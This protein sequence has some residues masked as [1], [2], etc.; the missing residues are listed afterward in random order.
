VEIDLDLALEGLKEL[1]HGQ[2]LEVNFDGPNGP[3]RELRKR[4][5]LPTNTT[6]YFGFKLNVSLSTGASKLS[7]FGKVPDW[8]KSSVSSSAELLNRFG[9]G[10]GENRSLK[11]TLAVDKP[12]SYGLYLKV[13]E[14]ARVL[15]SRWSG[16]PDEEL[17]HWD[18]NNLYAAFQHK[19][20]NLLEV[21]VSIRNSESRRFMI[22]QE[23][24]VLQNPAE[25]DFAKALRVGYLT[26]DNLIGMKE[27]HTHEHGP[28]FRIEK[29]RFHNLFPGHKVISLSK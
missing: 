29:S 7:L 19:F 21:T 15:T 5:N 22:L 20:Q 23:L 9:V 26:V 3:S 27:G 28:L 11:C 17:C 10:E 18:I 13:D 24:R 2:L 1:G 12:N 6:K 14:T 25:V 16:S 4:L 8:Q